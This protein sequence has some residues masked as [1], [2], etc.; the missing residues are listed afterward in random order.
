M[1]GLILLLSILIATTACDQSTGPGPGPGFSFSCHAQTYGSA[2]TQQIALG[3]LDS[4][5]NLDAVFSNMGFDSSRVLLNDGQA[6]FTY[7]DQKLTDIA[8]GIALGDLDSDGDLDLFFSGAGFTWDG[9]TYYRQNRIYF[10]DGA[11]H[12]TDSGQDLGD[13]DLSGT[14]VH[15]IDIDCDGDLDAHVNYYEAPLTIGRIYLND[16][17]GMFTLRPGTIAGSISWG[18]LDS[19]GDVDMFTK[20]ADDARRVFTNDGAG[21]F[22][23]IWSDTD[24]D[25][26]VGRT[27][28]TLG[29]VD[30]DGD[31]DA[32]DFNGSSQQNRPARVWFNDG[33]GQFT[34]GSGAIGDFGS[35]RPLLADLD[36]DSDL[37]ALLIQIFDESQIWLNNG[38]GVYSDSGLRL[39]VTGMAGV[40]ACSDLDSD[41]DLDLFLACYG[42]GGPNE[43]WLNIQ[44]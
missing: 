9:V 25:L 35:L 23:E 8:H 33:S 41:G 44:P 34:P 38:S 15:L 19:D 28:P 42:D 3:D 14:G 39:G 16:G 4:D 31:L 11:A 29:D 24:L 37:D 22:T 2:R 30:G 21:T 1:N 43:V 40:P 32:F 13:V 12:F 10:N 20:V 6:A 5:G 27:A 36:G 26:P 17:S 18:D 7:T